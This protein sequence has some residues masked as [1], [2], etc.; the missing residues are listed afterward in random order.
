[1]ASACVNAQ[2]PVALVYT[3]PAGCD[4]C[5]ESLGA[6][7]SQAGFDVVI[8]PV[9]GITDAALAHTALYAQ[10]GGGQDLLAARAA[11]PDATWARL[12]QWVAH[13]GHYL[14]TCMGAYLAGRTID[15]AGQVAGLG[16]F[17]GDTD[18]EFATDVAQIASVTWRGKSRA[19]YVQDPP[20]L[21]VD[22]D[23]PGVDV[24]ATFAD[25]NPAAILA[26]HGTGAAGL[27]GP[28]PE[29]DATWYAEDQLTDPDGVDADLLV[30][31]VTRLM[32]K[33]TQR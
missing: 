25:G 30:D 10:P 33:G 12:E 8:T 4:G 31:F 19:M 26:L 13:G 6:V 24:E 29:A 28:H 21:I 1:V 23:A 32:A 27:I 16:L 22:A 7:L 3:G 20:K 2:K 9:E 17:P 15:D 18:G 5:S 11:F 14:G